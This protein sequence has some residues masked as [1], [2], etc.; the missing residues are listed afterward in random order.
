MKTVTITEGLRFGVGADSLLDEARGEA[1]DFERVTDAGGGQESTAYMKLITTQQ[2]LV[3]ALDVSVSASVRYGLASV[4]AR[5]KFAEEH[6]VND[7][8]VYLLLHAST[9]NSPK[10]MASPK[11]KPEAVA[12]YN[13]DPEEFRR[14]YGDSFVDVVYDGGDLNVLF[15]FHTHDESSKQTISAGL[16]GSVGG[17]I[18]GGSVTADFN[19][20]VEEAKKSS[21]MEIRAF[22]SG[23]RGVLNPASMD[24]AIE[25]YKKFN[26]QVSDAGIAYKASLKPWEYLPLPE[27]PTWAETLARRDT[28][29]H[30]GMYVL[31]A[32]Q[33][34][35]Q[36]DYILANEHEF[37][38]PD[39]D[40]LK[41][42]RDQIN[43][44]IPLCAQRAKGCADDL[45]QCSLEGIS[46]Q[47]IAWPAR[48]EARDPL[49]AKLLELKHD[50][51]ARGYFSPDNQIGRPEEDYDH[52]PNRDGRWMIFYDQKDRA[53]PVAGV[54]WTPETQAH[55]VY[56]GIF[57]HYWQKGHCQ[58]P[59][60]YPKS[61]E[62]TLERI[63]HGDGTDRVSFFEN[64]AIWWDAQS[65]ATS[66]DLQ[67]TIPFDRVQDAARTVDLGAL[68]QPAQVEQPFEIAR[69]GRLISDVL[70]N[71]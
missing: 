50:S 63:F 26:Q 2:S 31:Q 4:D 34:R 57:A 21:E 71:R 11:L 55:V 29:E 39:L 56:G 3:E 6:A 7:S 69:Q 33:D 36:I 28:I 52:D 15:M 18:A 24:D 45:S 10:T 67:S 37:V 9:T 17:F 25:L 66:E 49:T 62:E 13:R 38:T 53:R 68:L 14:V 51:R 43:A 20:S 59:L 23:G 44:L 12:T 8:S 41:A 65:G 58:G 40:A 22:I 61:D 42:A 60:G 30:C 47:A 27:G 1:L 19:K 64:G 70:A 5:M 48:V 46:P 32:I 35:S 16:R 54:F